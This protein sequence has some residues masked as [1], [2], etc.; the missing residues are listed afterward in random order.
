M[1]EIS[2]CVDQMCCLGQNIQ[3]IFKTYELRLASPDLHHESQSQNQGPEDQGK[4]S[5]VFVAGARLK[6][7]LKNPV[8]NVN[9]MQIQY[10]MKFK[11]NAKHP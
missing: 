3:Y 5:E 11:G 2:S 9:N 1:F 4:A 7:A 10:L 6:G 8:I